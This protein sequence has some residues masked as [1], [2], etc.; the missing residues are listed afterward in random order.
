MGG[1]GRMVCACAALVLI[2]VSLP[3]A[4]AQPGNGQAPKTPTPSGERPAPPRDVVPL[5]RLHH[6]AQREIAFGLLAQVAAVRPET[7]RF[8]TDLETDFRVLDRRVVAIAEAHGIG[9]DRLRQAYA[10]DNA[11][12][13]E[14]EADDLDRLSM[15]RGADFDRQ[16]WVTLARDQRAASTLLA[17]T[18]GTVRSLDPLVAD[19]VHLLDRSTRRALAAHTGSETPPAH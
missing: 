4:A 3:G 11:A 18:A 17:A 19:T 10:E 5:S 9:E 13:L 12:A 6:M 15:L 14:G 8:A 2:G 1:F 16:F 7:M